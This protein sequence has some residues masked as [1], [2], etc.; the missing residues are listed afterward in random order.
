MRGMMKMNELTKDQKKAVLAKK[1]NFL[2]SAGAGSGKTKVLT[3]RVIE[4]LSSGQCS[5]DELLVLTFTD[6]AASDMK[7][8][9]RAKLVT[10]PLTAP[11]VSQI[12]SAYIMT[13][14][15][16]FRSL[17]AKYHYELGINGSLDVADE[18]LLEVELDNIVGSTLEEH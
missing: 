10:N 2:V 18:R 14:D 3:D 11:L 6:K 5:L 16:F 7:N 15:A 1:G 17:V 4:L 12:D 9:V 8:K 13:F